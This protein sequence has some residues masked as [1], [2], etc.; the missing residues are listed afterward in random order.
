[1]QKMTFGQV[2]I[3]KDVSAEAET[4]EGMRSL[5]ALAGITQAEEPPAKGTPSPGKAAATPASEP[6]TAPPAKRGRAAKPEPEPEEEAEEEEEEKPAAKKARTGKKAAAPEPEPEEEDEEEEETEDE[7]AEEEE[8]E[9]KPAPKKGKRGKIDPK[10]K[11]LQ[12]ATK[13]REV[14]AYIV[15]QGLDEFDAILAA[16]EEIKDQ[17]PLLR[18]VTDM[19]GR[20]RAAY[21]VVTVG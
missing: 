13:L 3:L 11:E 15:K 14:V 12:E 5:L 1:M 2:T 7:E 4:T 16:C 18:R 10:A 6:E 17:V 8:E 19:A 20:V 9:E 21:D